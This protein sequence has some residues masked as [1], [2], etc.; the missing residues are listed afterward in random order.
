VLFKNIEHQASVVSFLRGALSQN[1]LPHA[2]LF[3]GLPGSGQVD[4]ALTLAQ[5]LFCKEKK[6]NE[7]C[8]SCVNCHQAVQRAHPDLVWL[9]PEEDT[10]V[11][12]VEEIRA[13]ISRTHL[14]PLQ[15]PSKVFVIDRADCLNETAQNALLKTLE[16]PEGSAYFVLISYAAEKILPTVRSRTQHLNFNPTFMKSTDP[17]NPSP[18]F[19]EARQAVFSY[20]SKAASLKSASPDLGGLSREETLEVLEAVIR[21]L[22]EAL[23]I[24]SGA[25]SLLGT[26]EQRFTKESA[27][28][29]LGPDALIDRLETLADFREKIA[30]SVNTKLALSV[31]WEK[32]V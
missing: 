23:L 4:A 20:C 30:H 28:G 24:E 9:E 15:A 3:L 18:A 22:R 29:A 13:L 27:A 31:L 26:I 16:E 1:R 32:L 8:G 21:D 14:K 7:P 6:N 25:V 17:A 19:T 11:I 10:R 2:L 12:K 5:A